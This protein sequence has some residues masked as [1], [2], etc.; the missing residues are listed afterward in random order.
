MKTRGGN[1]RNE[2]APV[3]LDE[4]RVQPRPKYWRR[5]GRRSQQRLLVQPF[6]RRLNDDDRR[7]H[8]SRNINK[9]EERTRRGA[10][11]LRTDNLRTCGTS[12]TSTEADKKRTSHTE[13]ARSVHGDSTKHDVQPTSQLRRISSMIKA[14]RSGEEAP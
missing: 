1:D 11:T 6:A 9:R 13:W 7:A 3:P 8:A 5:S 4:K 10:N 12:T 2:H 14:Q